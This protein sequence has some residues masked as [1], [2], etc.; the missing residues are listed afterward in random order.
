MKIGRGVTDKGDVL[1]FLWT[2]QWP[3]SSEFYI[4]GVFR[5]P[6]EKEIADNAIKTAAALE[7][8]VSGVIT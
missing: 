6:Q 4:Y 2:C 3:N 5:T 1:L 7:E 8:L